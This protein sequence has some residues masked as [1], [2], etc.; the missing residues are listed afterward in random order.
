MRNLAASHAAE[1]ATWLD[2]KGDLESSIEQLESR[3]QGLV[4]ELDQAKADLAAVRGEKNNAD[5]LARMLADQ[6]KVAQQG[7]V[8][9]RDQRLT[10]EERNMEVE[11]RN[12][13]LSEHVDQITEQNL[14]LRQEKKQL[15]QQ[16]YLLQAE[17]K[18][19]AALTKQPPTVLAEVASGPALGRVLPLTEATATPIRGRIVELSGTL[20][21]V[22]VG[23]SDGVEP[24]MLFVIYR[25]SDYIGDLE[26]TDVEPN[27]AAGQ[28]TR[29]R[30]TPRVGDLVM[31][32]AGFAAQ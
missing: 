16:V 24:G 18:R 4:Q 32:E 17:N 3:N 10:L 29:T 11:R 26:V 9:Q 19:M 7:W 14:V 21:S 13:D 8:E 31:D 15:E 27:L 12:F 6:L 22:S 1:K 30:G 23:S 5:A 25:G 20:A 2:I 28:I